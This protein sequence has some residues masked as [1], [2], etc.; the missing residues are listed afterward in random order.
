[1]C[2]LSEDFF[3]WCCLASLL[4][5]SWSTTEIQW[6]L[7]FP[8]MLVVCQTMIVCS[9][10]EKDI[11]CNVCAQD[12]CALLSLCFYLF[13]G[14]V[15]GFR[16]RNVATLL[17]E[18][19]SWILLICWSKTVDWISFHVFYLFIILFRNLLYFGWRYSAEFAYFFPLSQCQY[20]LI[21]RLFWIYCCSIWIDC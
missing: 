14:M 15:D 8:K 10:E 2:F 11:V 21:G 16:S 18:E 20:S 13:W 17:G 5:I 6:C 12:Q 9:L 7:N 3:L 1:M 4:W 19:L